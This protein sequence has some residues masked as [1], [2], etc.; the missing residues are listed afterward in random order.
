MRNRVYAFVKEIPKGRVATY[1]QIAAHLGNRNLSRAVGNALHHNPNPK[2]IPCHRVVN[3][4]GEVSQAFAFG[5]A[6]AQRQLLEQE[7]IVFESDG[8]IDLKKYGI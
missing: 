8:K 7:G 5:G 4:K 3:A 6:A 2:E 1:G